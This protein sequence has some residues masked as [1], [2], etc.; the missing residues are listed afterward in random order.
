MQAIGRW[1]KLARASPRE[2]CVL[3]LI[4][5]LYPLLKFGLAV[6]IAV[7][8]SFVLDNLIRKLPH[9]DRVW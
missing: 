6:L 9:T 8:P 2:V 4:S 7:P 1:A 5:H 3:C